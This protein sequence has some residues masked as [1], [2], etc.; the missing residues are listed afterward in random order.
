METADG[1]GLSLR[2]ALA[3]AQG[4]GVDDTISFATGLSGTLTL[5]NDQLVINSN[6]V[7]NGDTDGDGKADI[8]ID[9][10]GASRVLEVTTGTSILRS[11]T[12][13]NGYSYTYEGGGVLVSGNATLTIEDTT[14]TGNTAYDADGG[15]L[16]VVDNANVNIVNSTIDN[17][18]ADN[19]HGGGILSS[20]TLTLANTTVS[21]NQAD[22]GDGGGIFVNG[23]LLTINNSTIAGNHANSGDGGGISGSG[24]YTIDMASTIVA[25]NTVSGGGS[26]PDAN[27]TIGSST[28]H[29]LVENTS[30]VSFTG[31]TTSNLSG[32]PGLGALADNG[33]T[34]QTLAITNGSAA[35]NEGANPDSLTTDQRGDGFNRE[36]LGQADIGAFEVQP[37]V[38]TTAADEDASTTSINSELNDGA[39]LSFREALAIVNSGAAGTNPTILFDPSLDGSE[40][41][42]WGTQFKIDQNV[43]I[44]GDINNDGIADIELNGS[45]AGTPYS[46]PYGVVIPIIRSRVL[47]I[48]D[49]EVD[50]N[51]LVITGGGGINVD[52]GGIHIAS[53]ADVTVRNSEVSHNSVGRIFNTIV[54]DGGGIYNKGSLTLENSVVQNNTAAGF[55]GGIQNRGDLEV[56]DSRF[57]TNSALAGG[58][59]SNTVTEIAEI[60]DTLFTDNRGWGAAVFNDGRLVLTGS[61]LELGRD[62]VIRETGVIIPSGYGGGLHN[63]DDG[64]AVLVNTTISRNAVD[65]G[66]GIFNQGELSATNLTLYGNYATTEG[67]G[68]QNE[69]GDLSLFNSTI[70]GNY[71]GTDGGGIHHD[72]GIGVLEIVNSIV[73]GNFKGNPGSFVQDPSE[74]S[75]GYRA[76]GVNIVGIGSDTDASDGVIQTPGQGDVFASVINTGFSHGE[77]GD[78][79]G[80]VETIGI[81]PWGDA[82][83]AGTTADLPADS[84]D[85]DIDSDTTE[86]LP[87]DAR[88][89]TRV[90]GS[91]PVDIGAVE[92]GTLVVTTLSDE[93]ANFG[94][95]LAAETADGDGLSLRE[96]LVLSRTSFGYTGIPRDIVFDPG[97]LGG[98]S[99]LT[100]GALEI[101]APVNINGDIDG[102][103]AP[104]ITLDALGNSRAFEIRS[105]DASLSGLTL[106][107]GD[108]TSSTDSTGVGGAVLVVLGEL[109]LQ[110]SVVTGNNATY[111]GGL[112]SLGILSLGNTT[113]SANTADVGGGIAIGSGSNLG[114]PVSATLDNS[115]VDGNTAVSF[116]GGIH[117]LGVLNLTNTTVGD[118]NASD[119]GG[120][121]TGNGASAEIVNSTISGNQATTDG[122]GIYSDGSAKLVNVTVH[123]NHAGQDGGGIRDQGTGGTL[124]IHNATIT[125]NLADSSG[126]GLHTDGGLSISNSISAGN[127][128]AADTD[129]A[130]AAGSATFDGVNLFSQTGA[131]DAEDIIE[132]DLGNIFATVVNVDP[133]GTGGASQFAAGQLAD[134]GGAVDSVQITTLGAAHNT[135]DNAALPADGQDLD[136]DSDSSETLPLDSLGNARI[137]DSTVDVGAVESQLPTPNN[138]PVFD[139]PLDDGSH[140]VTL[141]ENTANGTPVFDV[142]AN[143]GDGGP[144]D[145]VSYSI[146][147]GNLDL[148][149]DSDLPFAIDPSTGT[150]TVNDSHDI[151]FEGSGGSFNL[152]IQVD[153]GRATNSAST[154][155]LTVDLTDR[156]DTFLVTTLADESYDGN[157]A[158]AEIIDGTGLSLREAIGLSNASNGIPN[159]I[160]FDQALTGGSVVGVDNG[161]ITLGGTH[162]RITHDVLIDGDVDGDNIADIVVSGNG[163]SQVFYTKGGTS[164]LDALTMRDGDGNLRGGAVYIGEGNVTIRNSTI[165]DSQSAFGGGILTGAF[166]T[167]TI[168][169]TTISNNSANHGGGLYARGVTTLVDS[170]VTGNS[171]GQF[172]GGINTNNDL[173]IIGS[174]ISGNSIVGLSLPYV[175][176]GGGGIHNHGDL[177][178][179]N[180]TISDNSSTGVGG[181]VNSLLFSGNG[182]TSLINTTIHGNTSDMDGSGMYSGGTNGGPVIVQNSTVTGNHSG[183]SGGGILVNTDS[184]LT[185]SNSI[186]AANA[187]TS[188]NDITSNANTAFNGVNLFSQSG[189]GDSDDIIQPDLTLIFANTETIDPDG[190]PSN[191]DDFLAGELADNGGG[192]PTV[193]IL[194][195]GTAHNAGDNSALP[196]DNTDLDTD[197]NTSE[198]LP[199]DARGRDRVA[200]TTV[201]IGAFESNNTGPVLGIAGTTLTYRENNPALPIDAAGTLLDQNGD[202]D[203]DG[204]TLIAVISGNATAGDEISI[205]DNASGAINTDGTDLRNGNVVIGNLSAAEGTVTGNAALTITFNANA[206]NALVQETL[207]ALHFRNTSDDPGAA[208]RTISITANDK[209]LPPG[210]ATE[211]RDLIVIPVNDQPQLTIIADD[212]VFTEDGPAVSPFGTAQ[213]T[214]ASTVEVGQVFTG[215][216]MT[217]ANVSDG[218]DEILLFDGSPLQLTDGFTVA[219]SAINGLG[220]SVALIGNI[221][222]VSFSGAALSAAAMQTLIDGLTYNNTSDDPNTA[223]RIVTLTGLTDS[224]GSANGGSDTAALSAASTIDI[225]AVNDSP[226]A[227]DDH[228][229]TDELTPINGASNVLDDNG[230]GADGDAEND[231]L[232]VVEIN[233]TSFTPGVAFALPSGAILTMAADGTF[234]YD[235][236]GQFESVPAPGSGASNLIAV[237]SF[238]YSVSDNFAGSVPGVGTVTVSITGVD[239]EDMLLGTLNAEVLIGGLESDR[240]FAGA[241]DTVLAGESNDTIFSDSAFLGGLD[242]GPGWDTLTYD[243][244]TG[245]PGNFVGTN[246]EAVIG[247]EHDDGLSVLGATTPFTLDGRGGNDLLIGGNAGDILIGGPGFDRLL[248]GDGGDQL[249]G[250]DG[251]V[252]IGGDGGDTIISTGAV[253]AELDGGPGIDTLIYNTGVGVAGNLS[254]LGLEHIEGSQQGD[255][256]SFDGASTAVTLL[257]RGGND[258]LIG[259][260]GDDTINGGSGSDVLVG[261]GGR[262]SL[263]GGDGDALIGGEG[264]DDLTSTG[265][266]LRGLDGGLGFDTLTY[267]TSSGVGGGFTGLNV[268]HIIGSQHGD[269]FSLIGETIAVTLEGRGGDDMLIAG[270]GDDRLS[271]G[272]G[273]DILQGGLGTDTSLFDGN[274]AQYNVVANSD[275]THSVTDLL[276]TDGTDLLI[277]IEFI[278]FADS[279]LGL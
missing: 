275:G 199:V 21:D 39:G 85:V 235:P 165:S 24:S 82:V 184:N 204:G 145:S 157:P 186:V 123:G 5:T 256:L 60:R 78:N 216:M 249:L 263:V 33:G 103:L 261:G 174:V 68:I 231:P 11:V 217:V 246:V 147:A 132:S 239:N 102:N 31:T 37:L 162:L 2:E 113:V 277:E 84:Q 224:G 43:T 6:V 171:G 245:V 251:D 72:S 176:E 77:L 149:G 262:D 240:I 119:G 89:Q 4:N 71:A 150:I 207:R 66:G 55:G 80:P 47:S 26:G 272:Q 278:Q 193:A 255:G 209:N 56:I 121:F 38:V 182:V 241:G 183:G 253:L 106:T 151:D 14:I 212:P 12:V 35:H 59:I 163:G 101:F 87:V 254:G 211:T 36:S 237:D 117:N 250:G 214:L 46:T 244:P 40:I 139:A 175:S 41:K 73:L 128:A 233:G 170:I 196:T 213:A 133:D 173:T 208:V 146:I 148:D 105:F 17:N 138:A 206:T 88:G 50:L 153:D 259:G 131:G 155:S 234:T 218:A 242:G 177:T 266:T 127:S 10:D 189:A 228:F 154:S 273:N 8:T 144:T 99:N 141:D 172:G 267:D 45:Y 107:G 205:P 110:N 232:T 156:P 124:E 243:S 210:S 42:T 90:F 142:D 64:L 198:P 28:G 53:G 223:D 269:G 187:A 168:V 227:L 194:P 44:N 161:T 51:G 49:G 215:L 9:G 118:N 96:A 258:M 104:D 257:G 136:D 230:N 152:T 129:I 238:T 229:A 19:G 58:G 143:D 54:A 32:D 270:F 98:T 191:G 86:P 29:N 18:T 25:D 23:G 192:V 236:A 160:L 167:T 169:N 260:N 111:G 202:T 114:R 181:G 276:G 79:G 93:D 74:I 57:A 13:S 112:A 140:T 252:L 274:Q 92:T 268:E 76:T 62:W 108:A 126:G 97:L 271:G 120:I 221:A 15:G 225:V 95:T 226:V 130:D 16:A 3:L 65:K 166:A 265:T 125:G 137:F 248:G 134:L 188:D 178:V 94:S 83:D 1:G 179:I 70:S 48:T 197:S 222:T 67:G 63:D 158:G 190:T 220:L 81:L 185:I 30:G 279:L 34:T 100:L 201:D 69:F 164:T 115:T 203:W 7:V 22:N 200:D 27:V 159:T 219:S 180:S 52:G 91:E 75:G 20:A 122:G 264:D 116:G 109:D 195:G 61:T 247:S 135:G